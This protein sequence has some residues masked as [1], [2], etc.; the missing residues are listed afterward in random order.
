[1]KNRKTLG[2]E[3][4]KG[5]QKKGE[6]KQKE[7]MRTKDHVIT[8][9]SLFPVFGKFTVCVSACVASLMQICLLT[10]IVFLNSYTQDLSNQFLSTAIVCGAMHVMCHKYQLPKSK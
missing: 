9:R 7:D 1:V 4:L 10:V 8:T 2:Y 6:K 3:K 5:T